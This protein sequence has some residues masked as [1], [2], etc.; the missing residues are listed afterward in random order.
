MRGST[1]GVRGC[2]STRTTLG[3]REYVKTKTVIEL[4]EGELEG[5]QAATFPGYRCP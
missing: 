5:E 4:S 3:K 2:G 1:I